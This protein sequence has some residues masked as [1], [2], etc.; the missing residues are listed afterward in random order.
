L[1]LAERITVSSAQLLGRPL[2]QIMR[3]S[4]LDTG[5]GGQNLKWKNMSPR[6]CHDEIV[7]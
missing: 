4:G 3:F 1:N 5:G 7:Q 2:N 6:K